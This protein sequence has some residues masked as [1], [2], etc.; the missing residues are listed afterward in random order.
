MAI[1]M[2]LELMSNKIGPK[3]LLMTPF[4]LFEMPL[5]KIAKMEVRVAAARMSRFSSI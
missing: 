5:I 4:A 2:I 1:N 3:V